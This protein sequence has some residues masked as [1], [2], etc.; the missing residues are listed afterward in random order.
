MRKAKKIAHESLNTAVI[1]RFPGYLISNDRKTFFKD[2]NVYR[3][4]KALRDALPPADLERTHKWCVKREGY[5]YRAMQLS[6]NPL[7][8]ERDA[9]GGGNAA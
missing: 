3:G 8:T 9:S 6:S 2:G 5:G 4:L 1:L 7:P